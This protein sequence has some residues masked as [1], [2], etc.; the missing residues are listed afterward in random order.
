MHIVREE[1]VHFLNERS[2]TN[3]NRTETLVQFLVN[4][5]I[6]PKTVLTVFLANLPKRARF[7]VNDSNI[8]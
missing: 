6:L 2:G 7:S 5:E 4:I 8:S 1:I 3:Q